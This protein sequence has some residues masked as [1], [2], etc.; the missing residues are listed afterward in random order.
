MTKKRQR[1][2]RLDTPQ[3]VLPPDR[4]GKWQ[5]P[6]RPLV[7]GDWASF[8]LRIITRIEVVPGGCWLWRGSINPVYGHGEIGVAYR[9]YSAHRLA[10]R[11]FIGPVPPN[12]DVMHTCETKICV[13]PHHLRLGDANREALAKYGPPHFRVSKADLELIEARK[14]AQQS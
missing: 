13:K 7:D 2:I 11:I 1:G 8:V 3:L 4:R 5:N 6:E 9:T 10:Y 12:M 14:A